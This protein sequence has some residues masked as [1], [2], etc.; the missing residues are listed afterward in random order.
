MALPVAFMLS[1]QAAGMVF[2][3][4]GTKGQAELND[5]GAKIQQAGIEAN[6]NQTR[7]ETENETVQAMRELRK[8]LGSQI[9]VYAARG[10]AVGAGSAMAS[11]NESVGSFNQDERVRRLN[12]MGKETQLRGGAAISRLTNMSENQKLWKSFGSRSLNKFSTSG[13]GD[14]S[15]G[16]GFGLSSIGS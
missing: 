6:I 9:A 16:S 14:G 15:G 7:L 10:T 13:Y 2:D 5:L 11:I 8:N 4:F 3:Y 12:A 1:M